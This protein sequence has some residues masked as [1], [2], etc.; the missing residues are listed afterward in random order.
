MRRTRV[1][2][3]L[4]LGTLAAAAVGGRWLLRQVPFFRVRQVQLEGLRYLAPEQVLAS[5]QLASDQNLF[6]PLGP[7]E[8]RVRGVPGVMEVRAERVLP[9]TLRLVIV[10]QPAIAFVVGPDRLVPV[11]L[12][13][14]ALPYDPAASGLDLPV[15]EKLDSA[16]LAVLDLTRR[17]DSALYREV[18]TAGRDRDGSVWLELV[19]RRVLLR[20]APS[21]AEVRAVAIVSREL[22]ASGRPHREL[23]GRYSGWVIARRDR[24]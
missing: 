23:D 22:A 7:I 8:R 17:V 3:L 1:R 24:T 20:R 6:D 15:L 12:G 11:D 9:R 16:V 2:L 13:G 19:G 4:A 21:P 14:R 18:Q 10:E 5:L